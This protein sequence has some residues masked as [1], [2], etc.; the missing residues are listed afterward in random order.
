MPKEIVELTLNINFSEELKAEIDKAK[1]DWEKE[2]QAELDRLGTIV[3]GIEQIT[4]HRMRI[5]PQGTW[6]E[7]RPG[8]ALL[9]EGYKVNTGIEVDER[10]V[11]FP[12]DPEAATLLDYVEALEDKKRLAREIDVAMNGDKA[13]PQASLCDLLTDAQRANPAFLNRLVENAFSWALQDTNFLDP[14]STDRLVAATLA[15]MDA[16]DAAEWRSDLPEVN[17]KR[18]RDGK[19]P[20]SSKY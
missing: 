1:S 15:G 10:Q 18:E 19:P 2:R 3:N 6:T 17:A 12:S 11:T 13:A 20:I 8:A 4:I 9:S 16:K 7:W 5:G 14:K